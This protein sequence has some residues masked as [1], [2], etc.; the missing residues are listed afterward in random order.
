MNNEFEIC[1]LNASRDAYA[2]VFVSTRVNFGCPDQT[3]L[4]ASGAG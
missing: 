3:W 2:W 1:V 4:H